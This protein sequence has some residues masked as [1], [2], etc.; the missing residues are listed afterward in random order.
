MRLTLETDDGA[1][2]LMSYRGFRTGPPEV[3]ARLAS[4]ERVDPVEYYFRIVPF[5]ETGDPR[6]SWLNSIVCVGFGDR[7]AEG[8]PLHG[9]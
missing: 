6:Y 9:A 2:I 4:G 7:L 1:Q 5:F 8:L 3:L